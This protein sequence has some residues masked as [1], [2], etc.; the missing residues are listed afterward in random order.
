M[1]F[2]FK[3]VGKRL[4]TGSFDSTLK[5]WDA[6]ELFCERNGNKDKKPKSIDTDEFE[7]SQKF[8]V[9]NEKSF[10][11]HSSVNDKM[12]ESNIDDIDEPVIRYEVKQHA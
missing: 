3:L 5:V 12:D 2:F 11:A 7:T 10:R 4:F 9:E 8:T 1:N 6:S